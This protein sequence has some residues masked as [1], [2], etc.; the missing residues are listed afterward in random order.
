MRDMRQTSLECYKLLRTTD[1]GVRQ[2]RVLEGLDRFGPCTDLELV[3]FMDFRDANMVRPRR[4]ELVRLD[5]VEECGRRFCNISGRKA[6]VWRLKG[7]LG[8][9]NEA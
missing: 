1:L 4:N 5:M 8:E 9:F 2:L 6:I 3:K 7:M